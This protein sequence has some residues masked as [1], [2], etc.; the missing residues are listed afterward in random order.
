MLEE[1]WFESF[2]NIAIF[3]LNS[4]ESENVTILSDD[5]ILFEGIVETGTILFK[6]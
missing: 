1:D 6:L 2:D 3:S 5:F 4:V